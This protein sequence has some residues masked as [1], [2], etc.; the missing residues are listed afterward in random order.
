M[1][2]LAISR[3][4]DHNDAKHGKGVYKF[5]NG[6]KYEGMYVAGKKDGFG[7]FEYPN[8]DK[9]WGEW[10]ADKKEGKGSY[11]WGKGGE[12][13]VGIYI[14][15]LDKSNGAGAYWSSDKSKAWKNDSGKKGA[16]LTLAQAKKAAQD[17]GLPL[18][19]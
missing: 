8:G 16:V 9:Y 18:P 4:D 11:H 12:Y 14:D 5:A 19:F 13:K 3:I 6:D 7:T 15:G 1:V 17:L 2:E 10:K